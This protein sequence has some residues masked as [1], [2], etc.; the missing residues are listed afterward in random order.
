MLHLDASKHEWLTLRPGAHTVLLLVADATGK[1]LAN[2]RLR[3][4]AGVTA[5]S[6]SSLIGLMGRTKYQAPPHR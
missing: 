3:I 6:D 5:G 1:N 4:P 2:G